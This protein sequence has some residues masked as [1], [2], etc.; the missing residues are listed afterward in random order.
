MKCSVLNCEGK[1]H[2]HGLCFKHYC[3]QRRH[4]DPLKTRR[5]GYVNEAGYHCVEI[6]GVN[7]LI[8]VLV[9]ERVLGKALPDGA[10]V[11][12][13]DENKTN[14]DPRNLVICPNRAYHQLIH[15]RMRALA[16]CGHA[17]WRKCNHC[18]Q[19]DDPNN[20]HIASTNNAYHSRCVNAYNRQYVKGKRIRKSNPKEN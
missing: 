1:P 10:I 9:A 2:G 16:A 7:K 20:L 5:I 18:K 13:S 4:G 14:N 19:Y 12:H 17:H 11:H 3:R 15:Q 8:H 6:N